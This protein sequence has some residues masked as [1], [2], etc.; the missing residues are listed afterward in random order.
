MRIW[1]ALWVQRIDTKIAALRQRQLEEE[2][3]RRNRPTP[4]EWTV[5]LGIGASRPPL[6][7]HAG[8]C[9]TAGTRRR[10]VDREE[11][12]RLLTAGLKACTHCQPDIQL[13]I[14]SSRSE[15][16][17]GRALRTHLRTSRPLSV[18]IGWDWS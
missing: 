4:P 2:H 6:Q 8:D 18:V 7:V 1:H 14:D 11:A 5:E 16:R 15:V 12:R 17:H 3:G 13:H 10:P 9:H